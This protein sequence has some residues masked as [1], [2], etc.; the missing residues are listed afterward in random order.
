M[1]SLRMFLLICFLANSSLSISQ[2][3]PF[4]DP[5]RLTGGN[6]DRNPS[7]ANSREYD[8]YPGYEWEFMTFERISGNTSNICVSRIGVSGSVG[9]EYYITSDS[10]INKNPSIAYNRA[11]NVIGPE[12]KYAVIVWQSDRFGR[13]SIFASRYI[14]GAGWSVPFIVDSSNADNVTPKICSI[15]SLRYSIVYQRGQDIMYKRYNILTNVF[16]PQGNTTMLIPEYCSNPNIK[17]VRFNS[18]GYS[19]IF[20]SF[21]RE[22]AAGHTGVYF[23]TGWKIQYLLLI[24]L[25]V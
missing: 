19:R 16:S 10:Y 7:F 14:K 24:T 23:A 12:I 25:I 11:T 15:D 9:E 13:Q 18:A 8:P 2:L 20:V 17:S 3:Y 6:N 22:I 21:D 4:S 1:K 5:I